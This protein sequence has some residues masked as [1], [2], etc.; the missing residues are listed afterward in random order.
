MITLELPDG[1]MRPTLITDIDSIRVA[2]G[3]TDL[4]ELVRLGVIVTYTDGTR[5]AVVGSF[6]SV[7]AKIAAVA[8]TLDDIVGLHAELGQSIAAAAPKTRTPADVLTDPQPGIARRLSV[9]VRGDFR[10]ADASKWRMRLTRANLK[11]SALSRALFSFTSASTSNADQIAKTI[12]WLDDNP[13]HPFIVRISD[14]V[15][16]SDALTD[17]QRVTP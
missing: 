16:I 5:D 11:D 4:P 2:R 1:T 13:G 8:M 14:T 9:D 6:A 12:A 3:G 7:C 10:L 17:P 15:R